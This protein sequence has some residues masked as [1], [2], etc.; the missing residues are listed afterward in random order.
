[1]VD[2]ELL[3]EMRKDILEESKRDEEHEHKIRTDYEYALEELD[4]SEC[5]LHQAV[6]TIRRMS[7]EMNEYG[8]VTSPQEL[9]DIY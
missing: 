3:K 7:K 5:P 1:M 8:W 2:R 6:A 9:L 4:K